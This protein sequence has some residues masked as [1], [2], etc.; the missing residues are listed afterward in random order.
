MVTLSWWNELWLNEG[1]AQFVSYLGVEHLGPSLGEAWHFFIK[2]EL[3]TVLELD[4]YN[5]THPI[6]VPISDPAEIGKVFDSISYSK[7][8]SV[9]R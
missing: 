4:A 2:D 9:L 7:G 1:F 3:Q 6:N 5:N 8:A